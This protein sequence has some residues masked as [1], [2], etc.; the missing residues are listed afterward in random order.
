M[1]EGGREGER[2]SGEKNGEVGG[3]RGDFLRP[4]IFY[5]DFLPPSL[6]YALATQANIF[7]ASKTFL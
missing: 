4:F 5:F 2:K 7:V 6:L 3:R 1:G